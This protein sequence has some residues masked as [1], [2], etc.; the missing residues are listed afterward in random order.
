M[1]VVYKARQRSLNRIIALKLILSGRF[2]SKESVE[3]LRAEATAAAALRHPNIVAIHE[4]GQVDGQHYFTMDYVAGRSLAEIVCERPVS[5]DR[6]AAY[7]RVI[8]EAM[9]EA[10]HHGTL[11]RDLKPSNVL[12]D[13]HDQPRVTDFGLA[14]RLDDGSDLTVSGKA[15]GSPGYMPPE[16]ALGK[17]N[18]IGPHSD[19]Y[20]MGALLY[21]LLT[22][23]APFAAE[24]TEATL[25]QALNND[26]VAPRV[27][28]PTVP[29]DLETICL[30][31][32]EKEPAS[33]YRT[34]QALADDLR[35]FENDEPI[36]ARPVS[37]PEKVWRWCRRRPAVAGLLMALTVS[38]LTGFVAVL[39]QW[40]RAESHALAESQQRRRA[41]V[42]VER[43]ELDDVDELL[44]ANDPATTLARLARL[45]RWNPTNRIAA[46]RLMAL[47]AQRDFAF[48]LVPAFQHDGPVTAAEFSPDGRTVVTASQDGTGRLWDAAGGQPVGAPMRHGGAVR[49]AR[50]SSDGNKIVTASADKTVR[51]WDARD[52][53]PLAE[54]IEHKMEV[55]S[56]EFSPDGK[57]LLTLC[58]DGVRVC[59]LAIAALNSRR[60]DTVNGEALRQNFCNPAHEFYLY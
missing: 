35:R 5:A 13:E 52:G 14:K 60:R 23:R 26:P 34:A 4:V 1:G 30:K 42:L 29:R 10:H 28:N 25:A 36:S 48:P 7:A 46:E 11:H 3:R 50:F 18:A 43:A 58:H 20:A 54:P 21:H 8:A 41:E 32:L 40:G 37:A 16:Q 51:V 53:H 19:V 55:T 27:L 9:E 47:L 49:S 39:W 15:I 31:C 6:A 38:L 22:G 17:R 12:I 2:A 56:A 59:A 33:R 57:K 24:T 45:L 44:R